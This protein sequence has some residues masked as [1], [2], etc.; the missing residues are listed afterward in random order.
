MPPPGLA[1]RLVTEGVR[2]RTGLNLKI[3]GDFALRLLPTIELVAQDV[4]LSDPGTPGAAPV[5][6]AR[7]VELRSS[8]WALLR[9]DR[10]VAEVKLIAPSVTLEVDETGR[11]SWRSI[12][13]NAAPMGGYSVDAV[14]ISDGRLAYRNTRYHLAVKAT[15][16][17]GTITNFSLDKFA[18]LTLSDVAIDL[19]RNATPGLLK[20]TKAVVTANGYDGQL[21]A[22]L[23]L[24]A[25]QASWR[26]A[27]AD[28]TVRL[29]QFSSNARSVS[30]DRIAAEAVALTGKA[31]LWRDGAS[32]TPITITAIAMGADGVRWDRIKG[33][34]TK[35]GAISFDRSTRNDGAQLKQLEFKASEVLARSLVQADVS[36]TWKQ[37]PVTGRIE[38]PAPIALDIRN[39]IPV[40]AAL[41]AAQ[42]RLVFHGDVVPGEPIRLR[43]RCKLSTDAADALAKWLG[44]DLPSALTGAVSITGDVTADHQ[45]I[46]LAAGKLNHGKTAV[47]GDVTLDLASRRP[48]LQGRLI[49]DAL[50]ADRYL[51][52]PPPRVTR[53]AQPISVVETVPEASIKDVLKAQLRAALAAPEGG[54]VGSLMIPVPTVKL[55]PSQAPPR[56]PRPIVWSDRP[57]D[58]SGLKALDLDLDVVVKS[59]KLRGRELSIAKLKAV[60]TDGSLAMDIDELASE[61][62]RL[63]GQV[64]FDGRQRVPAVTAKLTASGVELSQLLSQLGMT[65]LVAGASTIEAELNTRGTTQ[66]QLVAGLSGTISTRLGRGHVV[67]YDFSSIA[68]WLFGPRRFDPAKRTPI[69]RLD[70]DIVLDQGVAKRAKLTMDGPVIGLD[71]DG[72]VQLIDQRI[73]YRAR[74]RLP[75]STWIK[76]LSLRI[77]GD[78]SRPSV[79]PDLNLFARSP[80]QLMNPAALLEKTDIVD[81]ELAELAGQVLRRA[82]ARSAA[83][84]VV[85]MLQAL[86]RMAEGE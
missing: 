7:A 21:I 25:E 6:A 49:A 75:L 62:A 42:G 64:S 84:A 61:G 53:Q 58:H 70:T 3:D 77:F 33:L 86:Q 65:G 23:S 71:G 80:G 37:Q 14:T 9:G 24:D 67:G 30:V 79:A 48:V 78:W 18:S 52:L 73:D 15:G 60:L 35:L 74:F 16:A 43:G 72:V 44:F 29:K 26:G 46:A 40:A 1:K 5:L 81:A 38:L 59:S 34:T 22:A 82:E 55:M 31:L 8:A 2:E 19:Q 17:N 57:F 28:D 50:D 69:H 10:Q 54:P 66:K 36:F 76:A 68:T 63:S 83:P 51:G 20:L 32:G 45:R 39:R 47:S 4:A 27:G 12:A 56:A 11:K 41:N 85:E 13:H